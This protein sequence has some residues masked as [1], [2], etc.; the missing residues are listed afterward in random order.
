MDEVIKQAASGFKGLPY[1]L[2]RNRS[3]VINILWKL[4]QAWKKY[5]VL[6][7]WQQATGVFNPKEHI[8]HDITQFRSIALLN[9]EEKIFFAIL[10]TRFIL[11]LMRNTFIDTSCQKAKI[12]GFLRCIKNSFMILE[13]I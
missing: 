13:H 4:M 10:A 8:S 3:W 5:E 12:L 1:K 7:E 11:F 6:R 2:H 9:V